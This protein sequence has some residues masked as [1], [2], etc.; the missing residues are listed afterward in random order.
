MLELLPMRQWS[1]FSLWAKVN[2]QIL[3]LFKVI[4][5]ALAE[6]LAELRNQIILRLAGMVLL[7]LFTNQV[8]LRL[9]SSF[10]YCINLLKLLPRPSPRWR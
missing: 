2:S 9:T 5:T 4:M 6:G 10:V 8:H 7:V 1:I 3:S